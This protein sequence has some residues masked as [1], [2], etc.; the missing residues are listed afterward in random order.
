M[1]RALK[2]PIFI[3][4]SSGDNTSIT[5]IACNNY[6]SK[7]ILLRRRNDHFDAL[8]TKA[9]WVNISLKNTFNDSSILKLP[10][11]SNSHSREIRNI[12]KNNELPIIPI[13]TSG[14]SLEPVLLLLESLVNKRTVFTIVVTAF[15]KMSFI[16]SIAHY[17]KIH[18]LV[19]QNA[20]FTQG[21]KII[22]KAFMSIM[23]RLQLWQLIITKIIRKYHLSHLQVPSLTEVS[24]TQIA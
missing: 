12:I 19:K 8:T 23:I 7:P 4:Q 6:N 21:L 18:T 5:H 15:I 14:I 1:S 16:S 3:F 17:A 22:S 9:K 2:Q 13:F 24:T 10:F 11:I 20:I